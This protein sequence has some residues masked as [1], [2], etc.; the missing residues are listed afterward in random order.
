MVDGV[1]IPCGHQGGYGR[2]GGEELVSDGGIERFADNWPE[3]PIG[4]IGGDKDNTNDLLNPNPVGSGR[5]VIGTLPETHE[6]GKAPLASS[7]EGASGSSSPKNPRGIKHSLTCINVGNQDISILEKS[8][9][10]ND[11]MDLKRYKGSHG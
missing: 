3:D 10:G 4:A 11:N 7:L 2:G 8:S 5:K 9:N 6:I 1:I